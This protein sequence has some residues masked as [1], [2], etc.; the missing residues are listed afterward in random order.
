MTIREG[1]LVLA[2]GS[3]FEGELIG[4][5]PAAGAAT[6]EVVFNTS[7]SGF[8]EIISDPSYAG[9]MIAFT[10]PHIGNYGVN[11]HDAE[12]RGAF[13]RGVIVRD[14]AR[15]HSNHRATSHL[16]SML[17]R[18][19]IPGIAGI[20]TRR[21][22]RL[23][24]DVGAI[25]GAFGAGS[26]AELRAAAAAEPGTDGIDLVAQVTTSEPYFAGD[27]GRLI[28]AVD[29]GIKTTIVRNLAELG[30]VEVVPA[31]TP[32]TDILARRP[33]GVFLSN[34]P[35][36]PGV[37]QYATDEIAQLI[38]NVP[39]FGIC[40]GHQLLG[41][42]LGAGTVKL[43][44]GHHGGNHPV[45]NLVKGDIEITSQ[46]HNFAV[47]AGSFAGLGRQVRMTHV[48]LNDGVCEGLE[49]VGERCFSVQHH[50]EASP[51]PHDSRYLFAQFDAA[52]GGKVSA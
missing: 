10:Y 45:K 22:T 5:D 19:S 17:E 25:P 12:S 14:L 27:G 24:R 18:L 13:C 26:E 3:V 21:L 48:N 11:D 35:G 36:D 7:L 37:V 47:D 29:Y 32:A 15:R 6:G 1:L 42:A 39:I 2:D 40:L 51:G 44:F 30:R 52:M 41:R 46:N 16:T 31:S 38:G 9:Q 43:P 33:D 4:A 28:V 50:P 34:G 23:I 8:Q 20:D 49:V